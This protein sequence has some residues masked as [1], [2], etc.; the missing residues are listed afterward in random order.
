[1]A[2]ELTEGVVVQDKTGDGTTVSIRKR[3]SK[4]KDRCAPEAP[5]PG[6]TPSAWVYCTLQ[7]GP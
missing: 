1:M 4:L 3:W 7:G 2:A 5:F 6:E